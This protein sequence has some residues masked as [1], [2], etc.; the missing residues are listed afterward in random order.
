VLPGVQPALFEF[1]A[2]PAWRSIEFI[3]DLHLNPADPRTFDAWV[4]Y[5]GSSTA[6]AVWVLGDLFDAWVGDDAAGEAGS[7]EA[8]CAAALASAASRR[9]MAFM[10]GNRDFLVGAT[11]LERCGV[12]ALPDPTL[13]DA[14]G[15]RVVLTHGDAWCIADV[16]Y[17]RFR[18]QV[19]SPA[20]Q[21]SVLA[22]PLAERRVLAGQMREGSRHAQHT[23]PAQVASDV[24]A[25]L[26]L[27]WLQAAGSTELIHGHTHRP[28]TEALAPGYVRHV[29]SDWDFDGAQPRGEVLKLTRDGFSRHA[30]APPP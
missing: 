21:R 2:P 17:Q 27:Q 26:A 13:L 20:W 28:G 19:R 6:D 8:R 12:T 23:Q 25:E 30:V 16:A 4:A 5:L 24:D 1:R 29:L 3:S 7:F 22:R 14:W 18:A 9:P 10:A 11:M 15:R